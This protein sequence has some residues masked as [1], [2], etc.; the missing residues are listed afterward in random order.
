MKRHKVLLIALALFVALIL[1]VLGLKTLLTGSMS[2][3]GMFYRVPTDS[4]SPALEA[5]DWAWFEKVE[6]PDELRAGDI[7]LF[8][9]VIN[10]ERV[11][12][13][14]RIVNIYDGGGCLIFET[15][16]DQNPVVD[17]LTVHER[18]VLGVYR[19]KLPF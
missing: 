4:M 18:E 19:F 14:H 17:P 9:T 5:G 8:W 2:S 16:G 3:G 10:G 7:I 11:K 12:Y 15:K 1:G 6:D 13:A